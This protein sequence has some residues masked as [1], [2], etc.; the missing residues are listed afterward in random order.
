MIR[1][2]RYLPRL[3]GISVLAST[4]SL[5]SAP[6]DFSGAK[7]VDTLIAAAI[8]E[9]KIPGAVL[10]VGHQGHVVY[11]QAYGNR[12][13]VPA[14]E[15]MTLDT[16]FDCASLTKVVAT[17]TSVMRLF[18]L[19][20]IRP[21]EKVT[22]YLPEFQNG[23]SAITIRDL[24]THYSGLR[25]DLDLEPAWSGYETG[26]HKALIDVPAGP[27]EA[28][29]VYS[30]INFIL[31]GEIVHRVSGQTL[32]EF[33]RTQIFQPL[34][35]VNTE[36]Q[37]SPVLVP[38]IAPT[39]RLKTGEILRGVVDDPTARFMGGVAGHAGMFSTA[40]DLALFCQMMLNKGVNPSAGDEHPTRL[41]NPST[42]EL[43]TS[44][45]SPAG[46]KAVRGLGWDVDSP[47]SGPRGVLFPIGTSYGHTGFTGTSLWID[48]ASQTYVVL[49]SNAIHPVIGKAITPLRRNIATAVAAA[50]GYSHPTRV[51]RTGLDV[52]EE[53]HFQSLTGKRIALL[54][55]Q[56]G[57]N[58]KGQRN[59]DLML[60]AGLQITAILSPEHGFLGLEDQP[61]V[62]G[63]V[64]RAT[65][66]HV[67]SLFSE[68]H[69]RPTPEML[70]N[71]DTVVF[72]IADVGTRYY[73]YVTTMAYA[74]EECAK[75][76]KAFV[77]LDRPNPI[78][79]E[80]VEGPILDRANT[81]F[82]G[83][84]PMPVRHG[85]TVGEL[86]RMFNTE[87]RIGVDLTVVPVSGWR[88]ED[89][90]DSTGLPWINPSPNMRSLNAALLYPAVGI[91]EYSTNYS[92]GRGTATPF[93]WM[94]ADWI[95]GPALA[96]YLNARP[97]AGV[98][99]EP[100]R[101]TPEGN[102][103]ARIS[104]AGIRFSIENRDV[105]DS[106][107]LGVEI[108]CGLQKLFPGRIS[109]QANQRLIGSSA[110]VQAFQEGRTPEEIL[111]PEQARLEAFLAIRQK[112][113]LYE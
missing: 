30:D 31:M 81:S 43:F 37:P 53:E 47:F 24:M 49:M 99:S 70:R 85:M 41:F 92:V 42:I 83:Y 96:S 34:G 97:L 68:G 75:Q 8:A 79:G 84:F 13:L 46:L 48:P 60:A 80:H 36:F 6:P 100:V 93:E 56:T 23:K 33:A 32:A 108:A 19:G 52:L 72:D 61:N 94:G 104:I 90:F 95:D 3:I 112:Y 55:N 103:Y 2:M 50:F 86:A 17:T 22:T 107:R 7:T 101:F 105:L 44:G 1:H 58:R 35:M 9:H 106:G 57:V 16:I 29:F 69:N 40:G 51:V 102:H 67:F 20:K 66:I 76:H 77:V 5:Y 64:D 27:R 110:A 10:V 63:T 78:T 25:P 89:W 45:Q 15:P 38:R 39:E 109:F 65:G 59:V 26:I 111:A 18:E 98:R 4:A 54:T 11:S 12:A 21:D 82:V 71:V 73:T 74:M 87:K 28:K 113:L 62:S 14:S 91:L 88:R